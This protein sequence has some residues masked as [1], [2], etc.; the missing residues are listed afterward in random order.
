MSPAGGEV[1]AEVLADG[2]AVAEKCVCLTA[3]TCVPERSGV[4]PGRVGQGVHHLSLEHVESTEHTLC[5]RQQET[6]ATVQGC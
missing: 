1:N 3:P 5:H 2:T 4:E 6:K